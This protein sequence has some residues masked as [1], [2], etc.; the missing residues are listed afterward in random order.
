MCKIVK[1][2]FAKGSSRTPEYD[3]NALN[4]FK[5]YKQHLPGPVTFRQMT[6]NFV[7]LLMDIVAILDTDH[8]L[9]V[10]CSALEFSCGICDCRDRA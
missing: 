9:V 8:L 10:A 2:D 7:S 4:P 5:T 1:N 3:I 6:P